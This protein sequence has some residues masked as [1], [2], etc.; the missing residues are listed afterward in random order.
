MG[1][2]ALTYLLT[3]KALLPVVEAEAV[4]GRQHE[5]VIDQA[6]AALAA[7]RTDLRGTWGK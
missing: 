5:P 6:A 3:K 4:R 1:P 7:A 2:G